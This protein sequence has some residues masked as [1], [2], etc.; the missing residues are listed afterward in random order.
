MQEQ[1]QTAACVVHLHALP[2]R[3]FSSYPLILNSLPNFQKVYR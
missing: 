3:P 1:E 2:Q